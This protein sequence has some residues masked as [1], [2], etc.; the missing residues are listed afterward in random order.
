M[1]KHKLVLG[2]LLVINI[3]FLG[4]TNV[5]AEDFLYKRC[6]YKDGSGREQAFISYCPTSGVCIVES[7]N[8]R[9]TASTSYH[10]GSS[11]KDDACPLSA[12]YSGSG[13]AFYNTDNGKSKVTGRTSYIKTTDK[14]CSYK[15][16][17]WNYK[18]NI[19][20]EQNTTLNISVDK[21]LN[22]FG[23]LDENIWSSSNYY[24]VK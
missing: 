18:K 19:P 11:A 14:T 7:A 24:P 20:N 3:L 4:I 23:M 16:V 21:K 5:Y 15:M 13:I 2:L 6:E 10:S 8:G 12:S 9:K 17:S 22:I 1:K